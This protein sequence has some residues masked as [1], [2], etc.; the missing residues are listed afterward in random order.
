MQELLKQLTA[1]SG[2]NGVCLFVKTEK[3]LSDGIPVSLDD[4]LLSVV[5][6]EMFHMVKAGASAGLSVKFSFFYFD[7]YRLVVMPLEE[8]IS[9]LFLCSSQIDCATV[10]GAAAKLTCDV[11]EK[12]LLMLADKD[13]E[14]QLEDVLLEEIDSE[15]MPKIYDQIMVILSE[16]VGP[17]AED[18]MYDCL[19]KWKQSGDAVH[20]RIPDL[21]EMLVKE[22]GDSSYTVEFIEKMESIY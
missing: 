7:K 3:M 13:G 10:A 5:D 20:S 15:E 14:E 8:D 2:V 18:I 21:G 9:L 19:H 6:S 4:K 11:S 16:A 12:E 22:I 17:L 1:I